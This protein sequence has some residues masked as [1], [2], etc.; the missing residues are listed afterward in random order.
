[1]DNYLKYQKFKLSEPQHSYSF[2]LFQEG[3]L[4]LLMYQNNQ[5]VQ[6]DGV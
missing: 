5:G 4:L 2:P 3:E 6:D 1:M